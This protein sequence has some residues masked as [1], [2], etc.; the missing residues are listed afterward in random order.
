MWYRAFWGK[1]IVGKQIGFVADYCRVCHDIRAFSVKRVSKAEH[2]FFIPLER[3]RLLEHRQTCRECGVESSCQRGKFL[4]IAKVC[5]PSI[6]RLIEETFPGVHQAYADRMAQEREAVTVEP[7]DER[8]KRDALMM[9]AFHIAESRFRGGSPAEGIR[10]L[11]VALR[12]LN[13]TEDEIRDCLRYFR[14][15]R[16]KIGTQLRT[17]TV[18]DELFPERRKEGGRKYD[19]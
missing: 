15:M 3:G 12:P 7:G 8:D 2:V 9:E 5:D 14:R 4:Q 11:V 17:A 10:L 19:Y 18:M 16:R 1:S 13:P 6:E